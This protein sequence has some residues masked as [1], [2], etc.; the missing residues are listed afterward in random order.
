MIIICLV[1]V[2][3]AGIVSAE[4]PPNLPVIIHGNVNID[5][6]PAPPG[7]TISA[8]AGDSL[9]G[10][11][12]V[13]TAGTYGDIANDRL[14]VSAGADGTTIDFYV[15][16]IKATASATVKYYSADA[17]KLFQVDLNAQSSQSGGTSGTSGRSGSGGSGGGSGGDV[18]KNGTPAPTAIQK[19]GSLKESV[20]GATSTK[21]TP[22]TA[23]SP[24]QFK[25]F[26]ILLVF[27]LLVIAS[28]IIY[29]FK[30]SGGK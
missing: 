28:I 29:V 24:P 5:G 30:K 7:T 16:N 8:K 10:T 6:K 2:L 22:V 9:A 18:T 25:F 11:T 23:T 4:N 20:P 27:V 14:P 26:T 15:N 3:S 19:D 13:L 1:I 21:E 17:G 12:K